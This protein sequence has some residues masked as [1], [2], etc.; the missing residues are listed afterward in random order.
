[1]NFSE[2]NKCVFIHANKTAGRSISMAIFGNVREHL[3]IKE[4]FNLQFDKPEKEKRLEKCRT[5]Y[6]YQLLKKYWDHY[7]KFLII[8]NPWDR[9]LS[10]FFF[11]KREGIVKENT[12]FTT[13]IRNNHL[14]NDLWNSPCLNWV[15]DKDGNID[16][17]IFI[18]KFENLQEDFNFIC[19]KIGIERK[20][21]PHINSTTHSS[22]WE[23]YNDETNLT[24]P[25]HR[26]KKF[27][28]D[29][30]NG[31][32]ERNEVI[33]VEIKKHLEH[34]DGVM[35]GRAIY[36]NPYFL[37]EI[38]N[39]IFNNPNVPSRTELAEKLVEYV[40]EEAKKGTRVNQ[41]MR[42]T[43]GLYHGQSGAN[44]WKR[45]LSENMMARDSDFKKV[46]H[47]MKIAQNNEKS[48]QITS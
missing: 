36:Q 43:V 7:F 8:R 3:T 28:K 16:K 26:F 32:I 37:A 11:G 25:K 23:Y 35:I 22:Y 14:N 6:R 9:K 15:E 47:I 10:D 4:L 13:Y 42:H 27:I 46:D 48:N 2:K 44:K 30:V 17:N 19:D 24:F 29:V 34:C 20:K 12:D 38:E 33:L 5:D 39:K 45:Y 1:M 31:T 40:K 21:L 18:G 41:I